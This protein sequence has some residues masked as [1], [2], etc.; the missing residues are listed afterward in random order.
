MTTQQIFS[1]SPCI[2][3]RMV[4]DR[5]DWYIRTCADPFRGSVG[6][7]YF[8]AAFEAIDSDGANVVV[9]H[10]AH[11][12]QFI[13]ENTSLDDIHEFMRSEPPQSSDHDDPLDPADPSA[14]PTS[15]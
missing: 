13:V 9:V 6:P 14:A 7:D 12:G 8:S 4:T 3:M 10:T 5:R 15:G 2:K 11:S 1:L